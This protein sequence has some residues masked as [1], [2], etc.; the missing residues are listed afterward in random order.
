MPRKARSDQ[1]FDQS[2]YI[3]S[4]SKENMGRITAQYK[5]EFV[6]EFKEACAA[7]GLKQSE[8]FRKAMENVIEEAKAEK[9]K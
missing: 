5:K 3:Q 7:L 6:L 2:K 1:P 8:V 4:W 9:P